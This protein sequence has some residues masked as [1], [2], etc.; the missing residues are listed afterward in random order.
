MQSMKQQKEVIGRNLHDA[1]SRNLRKAA[2]Q[3]SVLRR[4]NLS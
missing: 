2:F 3:E 1:T 4:G